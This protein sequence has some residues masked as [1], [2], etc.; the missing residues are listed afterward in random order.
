MT[1]INKSYPP[2]FLPFYNPIEYS[3][4]PLAPQVINQKQA[5]HLPPVPPLRP[6]PLQPQNL[7][8][9]PLPPSSPD[10][11]LKEIVR[12]DEAPLP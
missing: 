6:P 2:I 9:Q 3:N 1:I 5:L 7:N 8:L 4:G 12:P 10:R 11:L